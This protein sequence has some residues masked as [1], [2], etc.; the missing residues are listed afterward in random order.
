MRLLVFSGARAWGGAE[1][2]LGHLL[3]ALGP[4][5]EPMVLG[6]DAAVVQRIA[7]RRPGMP[8]QLVP[9]IET[10]RDVRAMLR[11]R[12]AIAAARPDIIQL[13]LPVPFAEQY[14]VLAAVTVPGVRVVV[15]E[16]LPMAI[17]SRPGRVLKRLT[18]RRLAAHVAVGSGAAREIERLCALPYG[19]VRAVPNGVPDVPLP[20]TTRAPEFVVGGIGRLERQK[21]FDVL[22]RAVARVP[23]ARL[24]LVGDGRERGALQLLADECGLGDRFTVT[25]WVDNPREFL[26]SFDVVAMPSRS[27][28][29][30]LVLLE[31]ML[32]ARPVVA[33]GVGSIPDALRD[34]STGL[35]VPVDDVASL[36]G[37][38]RLL[39]TDPLLRRRLGAA[40]RE[41]ALACYTAEA[42]AT[43]YENLYAELLR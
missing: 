23:D 2:V 16:H 41:H 13:N 34:G 39:A 25:G 4:D 18:S 31:A 37:A 38:L 1:I 7:A 43:V 10:K 21:G 19:S 6:V 11:H 20:P 42:M 33:T 29:L 12:R 32:A 30:P 24:V 27:E 9:P 40:A 14:T 28:G 36:G 5:I 3:A 17:A 26:P 8:T 15:V 22:V 35:L